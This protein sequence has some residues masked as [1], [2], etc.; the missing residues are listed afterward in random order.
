MAKRWQWN[1]WTKRTGARNPSAVV[2]DRIV[3]EIRDAH[4]RGR[5]MESIADEFDLAPS[6][7]GKIIRRE[8]W[9]HVP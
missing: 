7:V 1:D 9:R 6:T 8:T 2:D 4:R 3:V 5:S